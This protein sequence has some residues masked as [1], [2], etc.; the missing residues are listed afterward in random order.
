MHMK[1]I[2]SILL[3]ALSFTLS[4]QT[5]P[6][7]FIGS[8]TGSSN[9]AP[10]AN[11][12]PDK[13]ITLPTSSVVLNGS[14][15]D[16]D[17]SISSYLWSKLSGP[18]S[19]SFSSTGVASPTV[20][21]LTEGTYVFLLTVTDNGGATGSDAVTVVVNS[22]A[23]P[24]ISFS[25]TSLTLAATNSG[26]ASPTQS[27]TAT[28]SNLT[29]PFVVT[30]PTN[31][32]GS[33][34][35]SSGFTGSLSLTP[36]SGAVSQ[37]LY[38]R[39]KDN[40]PVGSVSG[41]VTGASTGAAGATVALSGTV[42][43]VSGE[44]V[45]MRVNMGSSSSTSVPGMV[46]AFGDP[47]AAVI[48]VTDS[49]S[50]NVITASTRSTSYWS[51]GSGTTVVATG[52]EDSNDSTYYLPKEAVVSYWQYTPGPSN[53]AYTPGVNDGWEISGLNPAK[54]YTVKILGSRKSTNVTAASRGVNFYVVDN[55]GSQMINSN[56]K[57][58]TRFP[59][60]FTGKTPTPDGKLW[61]H[62]LR[63]DALNTFGAYWSWFE[64]IQED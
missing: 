24:T 38:T 5:R 18:S 64:I 26:T 57:G 20:S 15:T 36:S 22:A 28:G 52:G 11:A 17:G 25:P 12:G 40:A 9:V 58:N 63:D 42:N 51:A 34:S 49:R 14:G 43:A 29:A 6:I 33:L 56:I 47:D 21:S 46:S 8:Q 30:F 60:T 2:L 1:T 61:M 27:F 13:S 32:E 41:N 54:H 3:A 31:F 16:S 35:S 23:T 50:G 39:T 4:A 19:F 59:A 62:G 48:T 44:V 53:A 37:L 7:I 10:V 55:A 45:V